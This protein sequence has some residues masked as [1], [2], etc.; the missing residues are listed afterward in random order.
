MSQWEGDKEVGLSPGQTGGT[1][2]GVWVERPEGYGS[3]G[4]F[5]VD[6]SEQAAQKAKMLKSET[7]TH[8]S[9]EEY[10]RQIR[11]MQAIGRPVSGR[12]QIYVKPDM[13]PAQIH[14]YENMLRAFGEATPSRTAY[15]PS[16]TPYAPGI[17]A[18]QQGKRYDFPSYRTGRNESEFR[19][20][21]RFGQVIPRDLSEGL[22]SERMGRNY[23]EL[24]PENMKVSS[25]SKSFFTGSQGISDK[26]RGF[27]VST[28]WLPREVKESSGIKM[29]TFVFQKVRESAARLTEFFGTVP[30]TTEIWGRTAITAPSKLPGMLLLGGAT[31]AGGTAKQ[32]QTEPA[33]LFS[34]LI[35][36]AGVF[37]GAGKAKTGITDTARFWRKT[38]VPPETI[39]EP[40]VL[41]GL[42]RFPLA[43]RGTTG[44]Q[45][46]REFKIGKYRLPGTGGKTGGWHATPEAFAKETLTDIGTSESP[47]LYISPST[48]PHFWKI[49]SQFKLFGWDSPPESPTGIW[50][51]LTNIKRAPRYVSRELGTKTYMN[52]PGKTGSKFHSEFNKFLRNTAEKGTGYISAAFEKGI[53][54]EKEAIIPPD[55]PISRVSNQFYTKF[56]GK[57]VALMEYT[58]KKQAPVFESPF[59]F[60]G[61]SHGITVTRGTKGMVLAASGRYVRG[62]SRPTETYKD[63]S[64]RTAKIYSEY[65]K[66]KEPALTPSS[67]LSSIGRSSGR[68]TSS[69]V[70]KSSVSSKIWSGIS[71]MRSSISSPVKSTSSV[72]RT[73]ETSRVFSPSR[74]I[75]SST[76]T[77]RIF[78]PT[79]SIK[80]G[81]PFTPTP[82]KYPKLS[83]KLSGFKKKK[84]G[85]KTFGKFMEVSRVASVRRVLGLTT[86]RKKKRRK[87]KK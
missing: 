73:S 81:I 65:S 62:T 15:Y 69:S 31:V 35:L 57:K 12:D 67:V 78:S 40:Q 1:V 56:S 37:K 6:T 46:V 33:Q 82:P 4:A 28:A 14:A 16:F 54:P 51:E 74:S 75:I 76:K 11:Y 9:A 25:F 61:G 41:S 63:F 60:T 13:T 20:I 32:I 21:P 42:E 36:T 53:K 43:K 19:V 38:Y 68:E 52:M 64:R 87:S 24:L 83:F 66:Y 8:T 27:G 58:A 44:A 7:A 10:G 70:L 45:L 80:S 77:S 86:K 3:S 72:F 5:I 30:G 22:Q 29:G 17:S 48:S 26:I 18:Q 47:G 71:S 85:S 49:G 34:D 79:I 59:D 50:I 23:R 55:T 84:K 39:I 2:G